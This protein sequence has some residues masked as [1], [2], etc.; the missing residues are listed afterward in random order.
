VGGISNPVQRGWSGVSDNT[1]WSR[2]PC[3]VN[4]FRSYVFRLS[5]NEWTPLE[6]P[7]RCLAQWDGKNKVQ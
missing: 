1:W 3:P 2:A 7:K 5:I 4:R 6:S